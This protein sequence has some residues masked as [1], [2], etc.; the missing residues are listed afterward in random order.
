VVPQTVIHDAA[1]KRWL[2]FATP[3]EIIRTDHPQA[4]KALLR[5]VIQRVETQGLWAAGFLS[6]EAAPAFDPALTVRSS[7][8]FPLLWFGIFKEPEVLAA[9]EQSSWDEIPELAWHPSITRNE[10]DLAIAR[11]KQHIARG[12][13]YQVNYTLRMNAPTPPEFPTW[14]YFLRLVRGQQ[15][16]YC[17]YVDGGDFAVCSASPELFF[18]LD[19]EKL[20][21]QPMKGTV[22]RGRTTAEDHALSEWLMSSEKNRAENVMIVDMMRNDFGR[23]ARQSSVAV[24]ELFKLERY[25]TVWQ[26]TS[27]VTAATEAS[28]FDILAATFPAASV[29]GAP[30]PRTMRIISELESSPRQIYTG[31]IGF[32]APGRRAQFNVAIRTVSFN[33]A[34]AVAEYGVGGGIIWDSS[35][36]EEYEECLA[37]ARVLSHRSHDFEL[38]ETILWT[39]QE[40]FHLLEYH[41]ERLRDSAG[42]FGFDVSV[43]AIRRNL[44]ACA[45]QLSGNQRV[46]LLV[47]R[48]GEIKIQGCPLDDKPP[49]VPVALR[50]AAQ[51]VSSNDVY[52]YHKTT[53]RALYEQARSQ[54][55]R[56][57]DVI[58]WNEKGEITETTIYNI[59]VRLSDSDYI[60]PPVSCGLLAGT[61][62]RQLL[63]Q[64]RIREQVVTI[65]DLKHASEIAVINSVRGWRSAVLIS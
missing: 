43:D 39:P 57:D 5:R 23:I 17:A 46:R 4:V 18:R 48:T 32:I 2:A 49:A 3:L 53:N 44:D 63:E 28:L 52:L 38:L 34:G 11:V 31:A 21:S 27:Q 22:R 16:E 56:C 13:T 40:G 36:T 65:S 30:K 35:T 25:P 14:P 62:R 1:A 51:P 24:P 19:G 45:S 12:D 10:Y 20:T 6:Y 64:V 42:Y 50:L 59:V 8:T 61:Y 58:L 9:L 55:S 33:R 37:K 41:L 47:G 7:S 15:A 29:T 60:T 54:V 26:L